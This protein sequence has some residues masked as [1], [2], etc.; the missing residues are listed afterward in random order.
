MWNTLKLS[1]HLRM[2]SLNILMKASK[3]LYQ[4][5]MS[6][7]KFP[8]KIHT[9]TFQSRVSLGHMHDINGVRLKIFVVNEEKQ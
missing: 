7:L 4:Q 1:G 8:T 2:S 3:N 5:M 6:F 9:D